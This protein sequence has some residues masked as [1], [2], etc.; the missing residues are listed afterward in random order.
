MYTTLT[1]QAMHSSLW[2]IATQK[3][4]PTGDGSHVTTGCSQAI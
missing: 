4:T 2:A 3:L 1:S